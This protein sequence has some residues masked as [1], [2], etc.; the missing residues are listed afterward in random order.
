MLPE[1]FLLLSGYSGERFV[2]LRFMS[3]S[4]QMKVVA[5]TVP[6]M[7]GELMIRCAAELL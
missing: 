7:V 3:P 2:K 1:E 6:C 4:F 5:A